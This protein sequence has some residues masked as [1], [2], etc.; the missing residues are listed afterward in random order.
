MK[1]LTLSVLVLSSLLGTS[2]QANNTLTF[3]GEVTDQTCDV[4]IGGVYGDTSLLLQ[5]RSI[6]C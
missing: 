1:K 2:A 4:N 5:G 3:N 6:L